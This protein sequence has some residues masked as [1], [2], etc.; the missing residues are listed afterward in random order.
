MAVCA[1]CGTSNQEDANFCKQ[2]GRQLPNVAAQALLKPVTVLFTDVVDSTALGRRLATEALH[3]V[4][5]RFQQEAGRV[6]AEHGGEVQRNVGDGVQA[7]FGLPHVHPDDAF[8]AVRAAVAVHEMVR[9]LNTELRRDWGVELTLHTAVATGEVVVPSGHTRQ[10]ETAAEHINLVSDLTK[11]AGPDEILL[12]PRTYRLVR[13]SVRAERVPAPGTAADGHAYKLLELSQQPGVFPRFLLPMIGREWEQESLRIAYEGVLRHRH[14][15][16]VSVL[17]DAGVGKTRLIDEFLRGLSRRPDLQERPEILRGVCRRPS[18]ESTYYPMRQMLRH[19]A[20]IPADTPPAM[21][22]KRLEKLV[23]GDQRV[24]ARLVPFL[25][26]PGVAAEPR[27]TIRA[28]CRALE[29]MARRTPLVLVVDDLHWAEQPMLEMLEAA[30]DSLTESPV[31]L[32]AISRPEFLDDRRDWG[33]WVRNTVSLTL[34]PLSLTEA[35]Q[36]IEQILLGK[37]VDPRV[38]RAIAE[39]TGG[40]PLDIE[41]MMANLLEEG[42][43]R[44]ED[45]QWL[46][47][48][49]LS[50]LGR[51][52]TVNAAFTSRIERLQDVE[53]MVAVRAAVVGIQFRVTD[54]AEL[55]PE[56]QVPELPDKLASLVRK[57]LLRF[58]SEDGEPIDSR[59]E[60]YSFRHARY[61]EAAYEL[62]PMGD[63]AELHE[64]FATWL[65]GQDD[66]SPTWAER[67]AYHLRYAQEF[68]RQLRGDRAEQTWDLARRAGEWYVEA[69]RRFID[70]GT[71]PVPSATRAL[72]HALRLLPPGS[73][74]AFRAQLDLADTLQE[75]DPAQARE[76][77]A[78]VAQEARKIKHRPTECHAALGRLEVSWYLGAE[79]DYDKDLKQLD[80]LIQEF[81]KLEGLGG[82]HLQA[83][84]YRLV[85]NAYAATGATEDAIAAADRAVELIE[86]TPDTRLYAKIVGLR[87]LTMFWGPTPAEEV[88]RAANEAVDRA[89]E[90]G[91]FLLESTALGLLARAAAWRGDFEL[92]GEYNN[93]AKEAAPSLTDLLAAATGVISEATIEELA[94]NL[95]QAEWLLRRGLELLE[96]HQAPSTQANLSAMLAR[97]L[98]RQEQYEQAERFLRICRELAMPNQLDA[99]IKWRHLRG[100]LL[101]RTGKLDEAETL[102]R[103]AVARSRTSQQPIS[104]GDALYDLAE[105]L[106]RQG[107][108]E[109]ARFAAAE[110]L[111]R[112]R[113]KGHLVAARSTQ[114]LLAKLPLAAD[115][116]S[117]SQDGQNGHPVSPS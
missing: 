52:F 22:R 21:A 56:V 33:G 25:G 62:L 32:V 38:V 54:V 86:Q 98:I 59:D 71:F 43:L 40:S 87:L 19:A 108:L 5:G 28:I 89:K 12:A 55:L 94:G 24:V 97:V 88:I 75:P 53:R 77:Y 15:Y 72:R 37:R 36:M 67:V 110:A 57:E 14:G 103:D 20:G 99:Q 4:T 11:L 85:T 1:N 26:L 42:V 23:G 79:I 83:K 92:A 47:T 58:Q 117:Q 6:I 112:Y 66:T 78:S 109:E 46:L 68:T 93:R 111:E 116:T 35:E 3:Q 104:Q 61:H 74:E 39:K 10:L 8:N 96:R 7:A 64:R 60:T 51:H 95:D 49:E 44:L 82:V 91:L 102:C 114:Q 17:G 9:G 106:R 41:V 27:E 107:K 70:R 18:A 100:L 63:R 30:K 101:A 50:Q 105:V 45:D 13:N 34:K 31:L 69:A 113:Q 73:A 84:A 90:E 81:G 115:P 16:M 29:V 48:G 65:A 2:C 76:L 80:E